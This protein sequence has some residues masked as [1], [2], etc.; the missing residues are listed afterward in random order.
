MAATKAP[1]AAPAASPA[2]K[3]A[4]RTM[5]DLRLATESRK[6]AQAAKPVDD[7][8]IVDDLVPHIDRRAESLDRQ[9]NDLDGTVD[10]RAKA[11]RRRD[12]HVER[13]LSGSHRRPCKAS[14]AAMLGASYDG[15]HT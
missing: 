3:E 2:K 9:L 10:A 6:R 7:K 15:A 8:T 12:Q 14:L 1:A 4:P 5:R 13:R 11:A